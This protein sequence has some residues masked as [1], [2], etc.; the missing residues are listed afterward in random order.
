M[1]GGRALLRVRLC[2][3]GGILKSGQ[4]GQVEVDPNNRRIGV[5]WHLE[6]ARTEHLGNKAVVGTVLFAAAA[7]EVNRQPVV[8]QTL[9]VQHNAHAVRGRAAEVAMQLHAVPLQTTRTD[10]GVRPSIFTTIVCPAAT[11]PTPSGVPVKIRSPGCSVKSVDR[12]A[13][14]SSTDQIRCPMVEC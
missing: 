14:T 7:R 10:K 4:G 9:E 1:V 12:F 2:S 8:R 5:E 13:M 11:A 6:A 3:R